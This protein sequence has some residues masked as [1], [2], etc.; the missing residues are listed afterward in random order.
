MVMAIKTQHW[1][2]YLVMC[3]TRSS[4]YIYEPLHSRALLSPHTHS[5]NN[6]V[7]AKCEATSSTQL[8]R[9][10]GGASW[11]GTCNY[12]GCVT[13]PAHCFSKP[14][15]SPCFWNGRWLS[16]FFL[17]L[18][19]LQQ[20]CTRIY[21]CFHTR[22][23]WLS[24]NSNSVKVLIGRYRFQLLLFRNTQWFITRKWWWYIEGP[25]IG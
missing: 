10:T 5:H 22:W 6:N 25:T 17:P 24:T 15:D 9:C 12:S 1:Y 7:H 14:L 18:V 16:F 2:L 4:L 8:T 23:P 11:W 19:H 20:V 13:L 21:T 3:V